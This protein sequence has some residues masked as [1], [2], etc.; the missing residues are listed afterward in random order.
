MQ[1]CVLWVVGVYGLCPCAFCVR[2]HFGVKTD[3]WP[4]LHPNVY[5]WACTWMGSS[6]EGLGLGE[7]PGLGEAAGEGDGEG[8][9]AGAG[10]T[11]IRVYFQQGVA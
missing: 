5:R 9:L 8:L 6:L 7:G 1:V 10:C 4:P 11:E 3:G 2:V